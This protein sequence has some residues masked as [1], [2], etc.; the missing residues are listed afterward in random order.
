MLFYLGLILFV[1]ENSSKLVALNE[2][3]S[4]I[5]SI[6]GSISLVLGLLIPKFVLHELIKLAL[7]FDHN[8]QLLLLEIESCVK[9]LWVVWEIESV[10]KINI[11][12]PFLQ[13]VHVETERGNEF[14]VFVG[15]KPQSISL[16]LGSL[17]ELVINKQLIL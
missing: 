9:F 12:E 16:W 10:L 17:S 4:M 11:V 13:I 8:V 7:D 5:E 15:S 14:T 1:I 2:V 6:Y 3:Y